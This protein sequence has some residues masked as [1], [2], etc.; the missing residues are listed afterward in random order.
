MNI[1]NYA[2]NL[3]KISNLAANNQHHNDNEFEEI[4][5]QLE[6]QENKIYKEAMLL[7]KSQRTI[8]EDRKY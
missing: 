2:M 3:T 5:L 4:N 6:G 1:L 8:E 7:S